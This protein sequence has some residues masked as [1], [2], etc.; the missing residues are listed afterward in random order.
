MAAPFRALE[1][2]N[3]LWCWPALLEW[4][5]W[6]ERAV[7]RAVPGERAKVEERLGPA[8]VAVL[9]T[10]VLRPAI[11]GAGRRRVSRASAVCHR[12][13]SGRCF[14]SSGG[15]VPRSTAMASAFRL[16]FRTAETFITTASNARSMSARVGSLWLCPSPKDRLARR[17]AAGCVI[18]AAASSALSTRLSRALQDTSVTTSVVCP[19]HASLL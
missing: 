11:R 18:R 5:E 14:R 10:I 17:R 3:A 15:I 19:S 12:S 2:I 8:E 7:R 6:A 16:L 9:Q 4:A 1:R 13:H